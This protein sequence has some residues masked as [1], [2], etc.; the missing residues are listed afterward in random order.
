MNF[1]KGKTIC[2][3]PSI[4]NLYKY[5]QE[6]N[7]SAA[8]FLQSG[9]YDR[10][11]MVLT[12]ILQLCKKN[13]FKNDNAYSENEA[14]MCPECNNNRWGFFFEADGEEIEEI[15]TNERYT[16]LIGHPPPNIETDGILDDIDCGYIYQKLM[17]LPC[18]CL[19]GDDNV[20]STVALI[21]I[22]N[23]A[24][25]YHISSSRLK[26]RP[27]MKCAFQ[28]Y[29]LT[30]DC[31]IHSCRA[32]DEMSILVQMII[33]NNLGHLYSFMGDHSISRRC[34]EELIPLIMSV[35]DDKIRNFGRYRNIEIGYVNLEGFFRNISPLILIAQCA[36]AA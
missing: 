15:F 30:Q 32:G 13:D 34:I 28:F 36:D 20:T 17:R 19:L 7:H 22:F 18:R 16:R 1:Q 21:I 29:R 35:V 10:A 11:I 2:P 27:R 25:V 3:P 14:C 23:L 6:V 31:D 8:L 9:K 33:L 24:I 4:P 5:A 26:S 12:E